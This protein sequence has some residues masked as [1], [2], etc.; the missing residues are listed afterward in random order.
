[1]ENE[2]YNGLNPEELLI[3]SGLQDASLIRVHPRS[4]AEYSMINIDYGDNIWELECIFTIKD[5]H[6]LISDFSMAQINPK[7]IADKEPFIIF[8]YKLFY[9][10][11]TESENN[12]YKH[13]IE[14]AKRAYHNNNKIYTPDDVNEFK[15]II[16]KLLI[17][18]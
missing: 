16:N 3:S 7:I 12:I 5:N 2:K 17:D 14:I 10:N 8:A 18:D 6:V 4:T 11:L 9:K 1:M 13:Q 15:C